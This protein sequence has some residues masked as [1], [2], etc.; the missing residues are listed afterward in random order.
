[1][2]LRQ[3]FITEIGKANNL[4]YLFF[5]YIFSP[6]RTMSLFGEH[7]CINV[8]IAPEYLAFT[9]TALSVVICFVTVTGN[10]MVVLAIFID[11]NKELKTPFNYFVANLAI[12]DLFVGI[13]VDPLSI[14]YHYFE[15][16]ERRF[17]AAR[18]YLHFPYF[19]S[20]T[21]SVLSLAALTVDR[22]WAITSPLSYRLKLNSKRAGFVAA[23]IWAFAVMFSFVYLL[24]GYL[25]YA[26]VFA[27]TAIL[28]TF[29]IMLF[30]YL[31][32]VRA[33]KDQILQWEMTESGSADS[34]AKRQAIKWEKEVSKT[35][36]IMLALFLA[37]YL[38]SCVFIYIINL[39]SSCSCNFIHV[40][41]DIHILFILANSAVNPFVYAWRF[42]NIRKVIF[43]LLL[44]CRDYRKCRIFHG[45]PES[46]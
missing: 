38:P 11:P 36:L 35:C 29:L 23:G 41:R 46:N 16:S 37:S 8:P 15:G 17:P 1:M 42:E 10:M 44:G 33:L 3:T 32:I 9:T 34:Q 14:I 25:T 5:F 21:A 12:C 43:K 20:C 18:Y 28:A 6:H 13:V 45:N 31:K 22:Y 27:H 26:F 24:I 4:K 19:I 30:T 40:G 39:C 2:P 7:P